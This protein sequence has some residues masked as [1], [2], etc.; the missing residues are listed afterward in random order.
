MEV[1]GADGVNVGIVDRIERNHI[2]LTKKDSDKGLVAEVEGDKVRLS[3]VGA[4]AVTMGQEKW[5]GRGARR[6]GCACAGLRPS[7]RRP[8]RKQIGHRR[9]VHVDEPVTGSADHDNGRDGPQQQDRH[10]WSSSL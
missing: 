10:W 7:R 9:S 4:V 1:I 2:K 6:T 3:A 5:P 8:G